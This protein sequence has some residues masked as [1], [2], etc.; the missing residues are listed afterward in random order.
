MLSDDDNTLVRIV[1]FFGIWWHGIS[2]LFDDD[3]DNEELSISAIDNDD[4]VV[5]FDDLFADMI[6]FEFCR[7][8]ALLG[9]T[10]DW[11]DNGGGGGARISV[12]FL[13]A[14]HFSLSSFNLRSTI[15]DIFKMLIDDNFSC[16]LNHKLI[17]KL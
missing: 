11:A 12:D 9:V 2:L 1:A 7:L 10:C 13:V 4:T 14:T 3:D 17:G 15:S 5:R 6:L 16:I 8:S